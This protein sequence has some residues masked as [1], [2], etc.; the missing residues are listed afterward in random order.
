MT[1]D[2]APASSA[3]GNEA[4]GS[5]AIF[6]LARLRRSCSLCSLKVLCLPAS[7]GREDIERLDRIVMARRPLARGEVLFRAGQALGSL[8]VARE[9]VFK[10]VAADENGDLQVL[11]FQ[12]PGELMG[13]DALGSGFHACEAQALTRAD[14]CEVP[15]TQLETIAS[16]VPGLQH[17]LLRIMGQSMGRDQQHIEI[18]G[19]RNAQE[20]LA[21]FLHQLAERYRALG[22]SGDS[23]LLPMSRED[24][25]SYLGLVIETVS[26]TL[27]KMQDDGIIA[28]RAREV[29]ILDADRLNGLA[30]EFSGR[31]RAQQ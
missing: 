25:A 8:F 16:Q 1:E 3:P 4:A 17:Q 6:D 11:G 20:R 15:L 23:F 29:K 24:I 13:L 19:R 5:G 21:T 18:L 10:T 28:V 7:I 12:L 26:R 30:H 31:G 14:V 9:G 27:S 22:R 2:K